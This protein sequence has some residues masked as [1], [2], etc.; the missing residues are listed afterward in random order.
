MPARKKP[1]LN[2]ALNQAAGKQAPEPAPTAEPAK[3]ATYTVPPSRVGKR[4][5]AA[6]FDPAV[7]RQL[8]MLAAENDTSLQALMEEAIGDLFEKK[9]K[10]RLL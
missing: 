1:D 6:F 3:P 4:T 7:H 5:I 10:P 2:A 9:G 8:K